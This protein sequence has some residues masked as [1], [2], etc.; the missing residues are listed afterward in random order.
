MLARG[1]RSPAR[2]PPGGARRRR[3]DSSPAPRARTPA[4]SEEV[5]AAGEGVPAMA[6]RQE[7][8]IPNAVE[9][10]GQDVE[11]EAADEF[12]RRQRHGLAACGRRRAGIPVGEADLIVLDVEQ[13]IVGQGHAVRVAAD[14]VH[15]LLRTGTRRLGVDDPIDLAG[16]APTS[17]SRPAGAVCQRSGSRRPRRPPA[18][19][20]GRAAETGARARAPAGRSRARVARLDVAAARRGAA[21]LDRRH[22]AP[23]GGRAYGPRLLAIGATVAAEELLLG[24]RSLATTAK[25]LDMVFGTRLPRRDAG[26]GDGDAS[27]RSRADRARS[28]CRRLRPDERRDVMARSKEADGRR[29]PRAEC[30]TEGGRTAG[31]RDAEGVS[32]GRHEN[33]SKTRGGRAAAVVPPDPGNMERLL[34]ALSELPCGVAREPRAR[35]RD[36]IEADRPPGRRGGH[37]AP[38]PRRE[39]TQRSTLPASRRHR[40]RPTHRRPAGRSSNRRESRDG[41]GRRAQRS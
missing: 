22:D 37:R 36:R 17:R 41:P 1:A 34:A 25:Y 2:S 38:S 12:A 24:H 13:A 8:E 6:V 14:V 5:A 31:D 10:G 15:H 33:R 7:A 32:V 20:R 23:L 26:R 3:A 21:R 35:G 30:Q 4:R 27:C 16:R 39:R 9:A 40:N 28:G 18:T 29:S 11:Q 19:P